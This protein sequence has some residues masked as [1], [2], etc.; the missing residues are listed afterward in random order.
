MKRL[1]VIYLPLIV[2]P[3][4][5]CKIH[6]Q[7]LEDNHKID[8]LTKKILSSKNYKLLVNTPKGN[9]GDKILSPKIFFE[10]DGGQ[11]V[12]KESIDS[13]IRITNFLK[14]NSD[15]Q[16]RIEIHSDLR[17]SK[18]YNL[19]MTKRK[20]E[21]LLSEIRRITEYSNFENLHIEGLGGSLPLISNDQILKLSKRYNL[22]QLHRINERI[23]IHISAKK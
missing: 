1:F 20:A 13:V 8:T 18:E 5:M 15:Y 6:S 19:D 9:V 16:M 2:L 12:A 23:E 4:Q 22:N 3:F 11:Y 21:N 17:G 10:Y 14:R 7:N